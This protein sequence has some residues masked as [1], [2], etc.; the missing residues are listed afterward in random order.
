M[1]QIPDIQEERTATRVHINGLILSCSVLSSYYISPLLFFRHPCSLCSLIVCSREIAT[2]L[3]SKEGA[4][5]EKKKYLQ[6]QTDGRAVVKYKIESDKNKMQWIRGTGKYVTTPRLEIWGPMQYVQYIMVLIQ[7]KK[8]DPRV[9][10]L[11][12]ADSGV[13]TVCKRELTLTRK[14][15]YSD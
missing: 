12:I 11:K 4:D 8:Q 14:E 5:W 3:W 15:N 13:A 2:S 6:C 1:T 7:K 10:S 9:L